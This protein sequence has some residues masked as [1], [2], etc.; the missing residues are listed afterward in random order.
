MDISVTIKTKRGKETLVT[1][2][3]YD[4]V[5]VRTCY[6]GDVSMHNY[7][8]LVFR[9]NLIN[10]K[11]ED[12]NEYDTMTYQTFTES[13]KGHDRMATKWENETRDISTI[14]HYYD[15]EEEA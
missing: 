4:G 9:A 13:E 11:I 7:E 3:A 10:G 14:K 1:T 6:V 5:I 2:K 12:M 15:Y 8:T